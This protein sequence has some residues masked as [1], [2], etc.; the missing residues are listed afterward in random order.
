MQKKQAENLV[1]LTGEKYDW[2]NKRRK[3]RK[4]ARLFDKAGYPRYAERV[5][6]CASQLQFYAME[7]GEKQ[8]LSA[9]FCK[10]RLCPM[11]A[12][13]R[14]MRAGWKLSQVLDKVESDHEGVVFLFLTL[15][16]KNCP[17]KDLGATIGLL[18]K[19]WERLLDQKAMERAVKGWFRAVEITRPKLD[20]YHPHIHA[21]LAVEPSYLAKKSE[22]Y[23]TH[24]DCVERWQK[25]L[26]VPYKPSVRIQ[27]TKAKGQASG[28]RAAALEAAKYATKDSDYIDDR[29]TEEQGAKIVDD[30]TRALH[31]RRL[32]AYGGWLKDAARALDAE[33]LEDGDLVHVE[34]DTIRADVADYIETYHWHFGVGDYVLTSRV[35]NPLKVVRNDGEKD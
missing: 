26:R 9:N 27:T 23:I 2:K 22:T 31:R 7:S 29:L 34:P 4:L 1:V 21:I 20:E 3:E 6:N 16:V 13:R 18:T 24:A 19:A 25:A 32:T 35:V 11:C 28:G 10:L 17:G 5:A 15:T 8:L 33:D 12:A 30:Y 14:A